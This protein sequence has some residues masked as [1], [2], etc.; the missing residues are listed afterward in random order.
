MSTKRYN[1][2]LWSLPL[3]I[4]L[5][6]LGSSMIYVSQTARLALPKMDQATAALNNATQQLR[7]TT[8][9]V[10]DQVSNAPQTAKN[11][12]E[13]AG[14]GLAIGVARTVAAPQTIVTDKLPKPVQG[15]VDPVGFVTGLFK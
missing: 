15:V 3:M 10:Q 1:P 2:L 5:G 9:K 8:Q 7:D 6:V 4:G 11:V 14:K 13:Q 12:G